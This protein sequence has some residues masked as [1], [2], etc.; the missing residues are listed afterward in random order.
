M[1]DPASSVSL[2]VRPQFLTQTV[3]EQ[4]LQIHEITTHNR[5]QRVFEQLKKS[6]VMLLEDS[7]IRG[8]TSIFNT[9]NGVLTER[10]FGEFNQPQVTTH[11]TK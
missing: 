4:Q 8:H 5:H 11:S 9:V 6:H 10:F 7:R 3:N 1:D 2:K